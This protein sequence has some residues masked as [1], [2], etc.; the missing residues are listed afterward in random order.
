LRADR[1]VAVVD[2]LVVDAVP[3]AA[4]ASGAKRQPAAV[5]LLRFRRC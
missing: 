3:L 4:V 2:R 1:S 5:T